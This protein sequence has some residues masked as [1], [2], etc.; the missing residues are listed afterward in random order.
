MTE[1]S[2]Q[3]N[4]AAAVLWEATGRPSNR[5]SIM[6]KKKKNTG[7]PYEKLVQGIFQ[8]IHDQEQV[9][10]ITV[11]QN[12]TCRAKYPRIKLTFIGSFRK[13]G[14]NTK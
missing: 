3:S 9:A 7:V 8:A 1:D 2:Q 14:L 5:L 10:T 4:R 12:K 11:E 13:V 6:T